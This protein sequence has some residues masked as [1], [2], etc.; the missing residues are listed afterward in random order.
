MVKALWPIRSVTKKCSHS[1]DSMKVSMILNTFCQK[2]KKKQIFFI[3]L[4]ILCSSEDRLVLK[5]WL[6]YTWNNTFLQLFQ[7]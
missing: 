3:S 6:W 2:Y 1:L 4:L 7:V 5:K